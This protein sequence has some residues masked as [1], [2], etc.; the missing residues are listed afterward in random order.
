MGMG[1]SQTM[2]SEY[3]VGTLVVDMFDAKSKN[4]VFRGTAEDELSDNPEKNAK[5]LEKAS[6]KMLKNFPPSAKDKK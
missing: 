4:L 6:S 5:K 1:T 3:Q 2:V